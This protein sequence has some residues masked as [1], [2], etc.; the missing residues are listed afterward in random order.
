[1]GFLSGV[2][3]AASGFLTGGWGGALSSAAQF[4]A[5]DDTNDQNRAMAGDQ[6]RFQ[7]MMSDTAHT[8]E[9]KDLKK[10]G[11]NP[12]LSARYGG[13][14]TPAGATATMM[15]PA[16]AADRGASNSLTRQLAQAQIRTQDAQA[17]LA[18]AE[19]DKVRAETP[20]VSA[21]SGLKVIEHDLARYFHDKGMDRWLR[22]RL[23]EADGGQ[24]IVRHLRANIDWNTADALDKQAR[25]RGYKSWEAMVS[26]K[27]FR[28]GLV[29]LSLRELEVPE[30]SAYADFFRSEAGRLAPYLNSAE[31]AGRIVRDVGGIGLRI[32][33]SFR[34]G[35]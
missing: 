35:R 33:R 29:D 24:A 30:A 15:N 3:G 34:R 10:A 14:S 11:L 7:K 22:E 9:V 28:R 18:S 26:D 12:M 16:E 8:R 21:G 20:G 4:L 31:S 17:A 23:M 13:A 6:M 2:L 1:M 32:P 25:D 19:A 27:D 5:A